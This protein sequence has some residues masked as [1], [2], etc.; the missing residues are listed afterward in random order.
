[1]TKDGM[2]TLPSG[3]EY[4]VSKDFILFGNSRGIVRSGRLVTLI[5]GDLKQEKLVVE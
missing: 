1:M 4:R 3:L 2:G 5:L